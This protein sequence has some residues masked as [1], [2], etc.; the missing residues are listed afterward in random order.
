M[1]LVFILA[2]LVCL[3]L[4]LV[5]GSYIGYALPRPVL[6]LF[7]AALVGAGLWSWMRGAQVEEAIASVEANVLLFVVV[8]PSL[9][10]AVGGGLLGLRRR[11]GA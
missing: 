10:G 9:F 1:I 5:L 3:V 6:L 2:A 8:G 11:N 4:G 7:W